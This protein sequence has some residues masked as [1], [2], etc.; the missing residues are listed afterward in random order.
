MAEPGCLTW[1]IAVCDECCQVKQFT[2]ERARDQW[3]K[4]HPHE[5][6]A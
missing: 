6:N 5:V 4:F 1:H 2:T 3:Q